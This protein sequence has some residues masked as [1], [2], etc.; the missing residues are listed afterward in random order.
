MPAHWRVLW[1]ASQ[2][3]L[4]RGKAMMKTY[5]EEGTVLSNYANIL[6]LLLRLRQASAPT[7]CDRP[8]PAHSVAGG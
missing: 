2:A 1:R 5:L 3:L 8:Q 4:T 6:E 7:R